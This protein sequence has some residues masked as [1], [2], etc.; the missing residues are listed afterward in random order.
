MDKDKRIRIVGLLK[1]EGLTLDEK[2]FIRTIKETRESINWPYPHAFILE[3][4]V[5]IIE[6]EILGYIT[7][8]CENIGGKEYK[9]RYFLNGEQKEIWLHPFQLEKVK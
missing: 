8:I 5:K 6:L 1:K 2:N 9:V 7:Q 4:K 3:D